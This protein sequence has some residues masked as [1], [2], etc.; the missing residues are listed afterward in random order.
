[1]ADG[2][3]GRSV[4]GD[5]TE[6]ALIVAAE[7]LGLDPEETRRR[8]RRLDS[9][10]FES[11]RQYMATLNESPEGEAAGEPRLYLKGAPGV[12]LE[13]CQVSA[14]GGTLDPEAVLGEIERMSSRGIR[15]LA[16]ASKPPPGL[17]AIRE[18]DAG[19]G[20]T[21][22]GLVGM[23]DPPRQ[24]AIEAIA[25]CHDAGITVKMIT[26]DYPGTAAAIGRQVGPIGEA[27]TDG[28][29]TGRV[30]DGLSEEEIL[31][32]A[33]HTNVFARVAPSTRYASCAPC[34][35]TARSQR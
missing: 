7:K 16:F 3:D 17:D 20:L 33:A 21:F 26:G 2:E 23:T 14:G 10:P 13:R 34:K 35:R 6:G 32:A 11:E 22:L 29:M 19:G 5:P 4:A 28:T 9:I 8:W 15:V 12:V 18:A 25:N 27:E 31:A 1:V 24:E 30:L